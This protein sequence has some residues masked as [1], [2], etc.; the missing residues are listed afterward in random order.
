LLREETLSSPIAV[1][2]W[3]TLNLHIA[4]GDRL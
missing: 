4:V 3:F 2:Q 1:D